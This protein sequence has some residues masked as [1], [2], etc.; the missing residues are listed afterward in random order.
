MNPCS[1]SPYVTSSLR[2][3]R[4]CRL[5]LL[6]VL[7]SAVI[8]RSESR[9]THHH[10]LLSL[11]RDPPNL[12]GQVPVFI[13]PRNWVA[14]LYPQTMGSLFVASYVSQGYGGGIRPRL[15]TGLTSNGSWSSLHI[16]GK[17]HKE[18]TASN[19]SS[20]VAYVSVAAIT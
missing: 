2:R 19:S 9:G 17:D 11:I 15:H 12:E 7:E 5:R 10:I 13:S 3:G 1:H 18:S 16:L 14:R 6:L 4:V 20:H 8:L